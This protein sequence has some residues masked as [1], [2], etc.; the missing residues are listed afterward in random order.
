MSTLKFYVF[1][2]IF[3]IKVFPVKDGSDDNSR[4]EP[5]MA[6]D[7]V[8]TFK[9]PFININQVRNG[10]SEENLI[11]KIMGTSYD[12]IEEGGIPYQSSVRSLGFTVNC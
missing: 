12:D 6:E 4:K 7:I 5:N 10:W 11:L 9:K 1:L 3:P 2:C 8:N